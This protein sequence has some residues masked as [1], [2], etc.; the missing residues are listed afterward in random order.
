MELQTARNS[1]FL[2]EIILSHENYLF[3][4]YFGSYLQTISNLVS[5]EGSFL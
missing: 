5:S 1:G 4:I 2:I 3:K